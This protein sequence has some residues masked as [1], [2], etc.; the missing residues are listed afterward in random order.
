MGVYYGSVYTYIFLL[1]ALVF[2]AYAQFKVSST[3]KKYLKVPSG[4]G[5]TGLETARMILDKNGLNNVKIERINGELTDHYDPRKKV[6]RLSDKV[7]RGDS[8]ASIS[9]AAHE[10]G[11]A[12][13]HEQGYLPLRLRSALVPIVNIGSQLVWP[14]IFL[15]FIISPFF[16]DLGI[17]LYLGVI[18]F[19]IVTLPVEFNASK[20]ALQELE[21][22]SLIISND[23]GSKKVLNAAA[24]TYV[25]ATLVALTQLIRLLSLRRRD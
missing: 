6:V 16:V 11:H 15:G 12:M 2:A 21:E 17:I 9:V 25:A 18:L 10:V 7:F 14:L 19:Q 3:F 24:M 23:K 5:Y 4:S 20:R 8:I 13:Q 22:G 1:P